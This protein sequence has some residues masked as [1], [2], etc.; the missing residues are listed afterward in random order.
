MPSIFEMHSAV[1]TSS[2]EV[3]LLNLGMANTAVVRSL[4]LCNAHTASTAAVDLF[5]TLGTA[6]DAIYINRYT[7]ITAS[8]TVQAMDGPFV[9]NG[10]DKLKLSGGTVSDLHVVASILKL[11]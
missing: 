2:S 3:V 8:Q 4:T 5:V 10:G 1:M 9:L 6:T 7:Q 11:S